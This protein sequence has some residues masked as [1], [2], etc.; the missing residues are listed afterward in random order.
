MLF[1]VVPGID[2]H[3]TASL[4]SSFKPDFPLRPNPRENGEILF[5]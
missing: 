4:G 2:M 3:G 5:Q 1:Q